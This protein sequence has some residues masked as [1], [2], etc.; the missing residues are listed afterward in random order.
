MIK[1]LY[2]SV[3]RLLGVK[4]FI[5]L[6]LVTRLYHLRYGGLQMKVV[7]L[8]G[9][10]VISFAT[11]VV[12]QSPLPPDQPSG[13]YTS[14]G[15]LYYWN[16]ARKTTCHV[17][18]PIQNRVMAKKGVTNRDAFFTPYNY[19]DGCLWPQGVY[20]PQGEGKAFYINSHSQICHIPTPALHSM[21]A[22]KFGVNE[23]SSFAIISSGLKNIGICPTPE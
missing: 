10:G 3:L 4:I 8:L 12:A 13:I 21:L 5:F 20:E 17:V 2:S 1:V 18:N 6:L 11:M 15:H 22:Q 14:Q 19:K 23:S 7:M 16:N 9:T